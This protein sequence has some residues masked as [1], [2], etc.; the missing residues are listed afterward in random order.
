MSREEGNGET[1]MRKAEI[2]RLVG[3][4]RQNIHKWLRRRGIKPVGKDER[5]GWMLFDRAEIA[6]AVALG[7]K[8]PGG[9][10]ADAKRRAAAI[11]NRK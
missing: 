10:E 6:A 4:P 11:A 9:Q 7:S 5:G 8:A 1:L 2:A 3:C